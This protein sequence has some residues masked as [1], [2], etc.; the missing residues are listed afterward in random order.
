MPPIQYKTS[1]SWMSAGGRLGVVKAGVPMVIQQCFYAS[2]ASSIS[3]VPLSNFDKTLSGAG[4][5]T[6]NATYDRTRANLAIVKDRLGRPLTLSEKI[7]YGHLENAK[8][9]DIVRG[10]SYL[11][12]LPDRVACQDATAQVR[13]Q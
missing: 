5:P 11:K 8:E 12:L 3:K 7:V 4:A 2:G 9:Q 6:I 10:K 13:K 1:L